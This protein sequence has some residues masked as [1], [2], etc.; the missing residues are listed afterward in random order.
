[1]IIDLNNLEEA[2]SGD[3]MVMCHRNRDGGM[4]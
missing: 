4:K 3:T 1:M 2:N